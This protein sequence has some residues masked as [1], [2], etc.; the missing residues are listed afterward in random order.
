MLLNAKNNN[1][2]VE[3]P[4]EFFP[5]EICDKYMFYL[6]R[7]PI[8]YD[9]IPDF[10]NSSIQGI[11]FPAPKG[12]VVEQTLLEDPIK[13]KGRGNLERWLDREFSITFKLCEGYIN[14]W[15]MFEILQHFYAYD[16][17]KY[18]LGDIVLQF[19][20]NVGY[21]LVAF[22][23]EKTLFTGMSGLELSFA[24]NV[25]DFKTFDCSFMYNYPHI[26]K[27]LD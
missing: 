27:R 14:Y 4:K 1:F 19:L 2:R 26:I 13:W 16:N 20:D 17:L 25:P 12:P 18:M 24:S 5:K 21:E 10:I 22:R 7:L 3:L 9:N 8:I 11:S 15:I 23:F 6:K